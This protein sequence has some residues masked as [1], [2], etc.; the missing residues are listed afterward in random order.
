MIVCIAYYFEA[1]G[2]PSPETTLES[3]LQLVLLRLA[4]RIRQRSG[5]GLTP[6]RLSG[7]S[8]IHRHGPIR[9]GELGRRERVG[10]STITRLEEEGLIARLQDPA[11]RR[12][13]LVQMTDRG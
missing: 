8:T 2:D 12:S 7:L 3:E 11:D 6:S 9:L 13:A 10:S 5:D 4:R 1:P